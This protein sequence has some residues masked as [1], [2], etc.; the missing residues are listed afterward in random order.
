[1]VG[2]G[3]VDG[4]IEARRAIEALRS[5]VPN[6]DA[7]RALGSAQAHVEERFWQELQ[8]A[9]D[10]LNTDRQAPGVLVAGDFGSGKSHLLEYLQHLALQQGFVCSKVVISKETPLHDPAKF[11]RA[12]VESA[13]VPDRRG[14]AFAE[15][16]AGLDPNSPRYAEFYRWVSRPDAGLNS[17]FPATV[18]LH[19]R[20]KDAEILDRIVSFWAG[21]PLNVSEI[22][23][24]LRAHDAAATYKLERVALRDLPLQ[25]FKFAPRLMIAAGYAGW[26]LL[27][28]ELELIGR[29]SFMQ[30]A[31]SYAALARWAGQLEAE[32]FPGLITVFTITSDF[33]PAVL[34]DRNDAEAVPGKLRAS[35]LDP[36]RLLASQAERG[37]RLIAREAVYLRSPDRQAIDATREQV[38]DVHARA[39]RWDPPSL[40]GDDEL[41]LRMR[42]YVRRWINEWDL[43][44]DD[45]LYQPRTVVADLSVDYSEEP[46]LE[47]PSQEDSGS[48]Q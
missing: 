43:K 19:E 34:V 44:R 15:I 41:A 26:V 32:S 27:V 16:A 1:M 5:G 46:A 18:F 21:D 33:A 40:A 17:R 24:W 48:S 42:Q 12:A 38:R 7:V 47:A 10:G 35:G 6:R 4:H 13:A 23:A 28:D 11:Y 9:K 36:E 25:R 37:M 31:R 20:V 14:A 29:Y 2:T 39:Y 30:R 22:R 3:A 8:T 45:P